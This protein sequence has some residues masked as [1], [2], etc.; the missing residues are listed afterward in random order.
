M[1]ARSQ[2]YGMCPASTVDAGH[3]AC[4]A[5]SYCCPQLQNPDDLQCAETAQ[6][7]DEY[8]CSRYLAVSSCSADAGSMGFDDATAAAYFPDAGEES[9]S[10][11]CVTYAYNYCMCQGGA[12]TLDCE[13]SNMD[14]CTNLNAQCLAAIECVAQATCETIHECPSCNVDAG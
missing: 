7:L 13:Q 4:D 10:A 12:P 9:Y 2:D 14:E 11:Q 3:A 8:Q 1:L 5:L 6:A